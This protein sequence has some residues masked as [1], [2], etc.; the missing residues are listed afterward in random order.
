MHRFQNRFALDTKS[1]KPIRPE[2]SDGRIGS[3]WTPNRKSRFAPNTPMGESVRAGHQIGKTDSPLNKNGKKSVRTD[4]PPR[5]K[6]VHRLSTY[7]TFWN[8]RFTTSPMVPLSAHSETV[9]VFFSQNPKSCAQEFD[10]VPK[11]VHRIC[12]HF[13]SCAQVLSPYQKPVMTFG[14]RMR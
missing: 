7:G 5:G 4:S 1:E 9:F 10:M 14:V 11:P 12:H 6:S 8:R 13:K 2:H 3:R